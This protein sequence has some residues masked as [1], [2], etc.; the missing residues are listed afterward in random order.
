MTTRAD[1]KLDVARESVRVA[2]KALSE[3]IVGECSGSDGLSAS[4][5]SEVGESMNMLISIRAKLTS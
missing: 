5:Y 3:I 2:I 1:E 4:F